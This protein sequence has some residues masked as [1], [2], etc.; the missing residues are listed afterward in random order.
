MH[1][2]AVKI[3]FATSAALLGG[4]GIAYAL[5]TSAAPRSDL[6]GATVNNSTANATTVV[7][8]NERS[9]QPLELVGV[10]L[11]EMKTPFETKLPEFPDLPTRADN[12][13]PATQVLPALPNKPRSLPV[14]VAIASLGLDAPV[15][16][17]G[18]QPNRSMEIPGAREAG[19][20]K[21]GALPGA[22]TGSAVL[23]G[24]VDH[25][26]SPGV[27][28]KLRT[29]N[30]GAEVVVTDDLGQ[31]HRYVVSERFQVS[32]KD[33]PIAELF[34]TDGPPVLTLITCGGVFRKSNRSYSDNIVLRA[35][36]SSEPTP[37]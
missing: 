4:A 15:I 32:K 27:F 36:L 19:W 26:G 2:L 30:I 33:L 12:D 24:H 8:G 9:G 37:T 3:V 6:S 23:A 17:V 11:F 14:K 22:V 21:H 13:R 7:A 16:S 29:L 20:Y 31:M 28:L 1:A 5:D 10:Q 34:R 35:T 18:L 25:A